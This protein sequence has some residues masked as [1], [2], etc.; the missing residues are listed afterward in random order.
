M[1]SL[2]SLLTSSRFSRFFRADGGSIPDRKDL[3]KNKPRTVPTDSHNLKVAQY[4]LCALS[5][6]PLV[7]PIVLDQIGKLYNKVAILEFLLD[8]S[9]Y[10]D[11]EQICGYIRSMK[12]T[13]TLTLT[14][15]PN[16]ASSDASSSTNNTNTDT[17]SLPSLFICPLSLKEMNGSLPFVALRPCGCVFALA[18][19]KAI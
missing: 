13:T 15:N 3:V 18:A 5:K 16:L 6:R 14:P 7:A 11:G 1:H 9:S 4:T 19:L 2:Y 17:S 8:R 10:G 12:D